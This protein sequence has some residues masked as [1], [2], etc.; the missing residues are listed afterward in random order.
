MI[1]N[2]VASCIHR[3]RW[4]PKNL[5]APTISAA[6]R[7]GSNDLGP[8]KIPIVVTNTYSQGFHQQRCWQFDLAKK[9]KWWFDHQSKYLVGGLEHFSIYFSNWRTKSHFSEGW[10]NHQP[11][12]LQPYFAGVHNE[13][14]PYF[15]GFWGESNR[16]GFRSRYGWDM[17]GDQ[18]MN[19]CG[20]LWLIIS[21]YPD[22]SRYIIYIYIT[23]CIYIYMVWTSLNKQYSQ[24]W[25][26]GKSTAKQWFSSTSD[27]HVGFFC[28]GFLFPEPCSTGTTSWFPQ[29]KPSRRLGWVHRKPSGNRT[30]DG[31][32]YWHLN[33]NIFI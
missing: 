27:P 32:I 12:M 19:C 10:L 17:A 30:W 33:G 20:I 23:I 15:W 5:L 21:K 16:T 8:K 11:V 28:T 26:E 6:K 7:T 3:G 24:A 18:M 4:P 1:R 29:E 2:W 25:I 9:T 13:I 14:S 31:Y 22:I